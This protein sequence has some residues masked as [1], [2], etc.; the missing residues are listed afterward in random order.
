MLSQYLLVR[1]RHT[2][3]NFG[4]NYRGYLRNVYLTPKVL[5]RE[6]IQDLFADG[7][8]GDLSDAHRVHLSSHTNEHTKCAASVSH[9]REDSHPPERHPNADAAE[10]QMGPSTG[11]PATDTQL[12][13]PAAPGSDAEP[14][15]ESAVQDTLEATKAEARARAR[16]CR[17]PRV[18]LW[19]ESALEGGFVV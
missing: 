14:A 12:D 8:H 6:A 10:Y 4:G 11:A 3:L 2:G 7:N 19:A 1:F 15:V 13:R 16:R 18:V 9:R 17:V 5:G